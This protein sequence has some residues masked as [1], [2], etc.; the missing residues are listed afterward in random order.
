MAQ[1]KQ[2]EP[3]ADSGAAD[4]AKAKFRAALDKKKAAQHHTAD[5]KGNTGNVHGSET[6]GPV[7]RTFRR[8]A[9]SA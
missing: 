1:N 6:S 2:E 5:G 4:D 8:R 3:A 9:G 7:Q